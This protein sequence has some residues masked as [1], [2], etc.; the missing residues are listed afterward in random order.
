MNIDKQIKG[1]EICINDLL[2]KNYEYF[3][4][5]PIRGTGFVISGDKYAVNLNG[6]IIAM[7]NNLQELEHITTAIYFVLREYKK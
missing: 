5:Q 3:Y 7:A 6:E 2:D 4:I 1:L